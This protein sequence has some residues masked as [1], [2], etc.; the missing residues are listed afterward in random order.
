MIYLKT[1]EEIELLRQ[2]NM[3]VAKTLGEVAKIIKP[4]VTTLE[5]DRVAEEFI[6]DN[7]GI[8]GFLDYQG[9]PNTLCTSVNE[10]VVH[11]IPNN[12][13]LEN[14][15]IVSVDCGVLKNEFY[16]DSA[17]TFEVGEVS[18]EKRDLLLTTKEALYKGIE[19]AVAG[20]RLGDIGNAVQ[21]HSE[22]RGYSVVREMVGHG[23][24]RNLHEAPEVPNY[25]R[26]GNGTLLKPGMVIAIE[27]MINLGK[28]NIV[29]ENDGWTIRTIDKK[30]SAHFEHTVA[31][32]KSEAD[33]L[34][35]FKFVEEILT[36]QS[37]N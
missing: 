10:Q 18:Q 3:L 20:K 14:G 27:P 17:Y 21:R 26:R 32:G 13:P 23:V 11:G 35:S 8:P 12:K 1:D 15:D 33:I 4:G 30:I 24:G 34:S 7:G 16:G 25:G 37:E 5:L 31:V 22:A 28:R 9:F 2:S 6:R 19:N 36:L 29:Q